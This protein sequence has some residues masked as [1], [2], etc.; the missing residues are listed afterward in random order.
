MSIFRKSRTVPST[1]QILAARK[2]VRAHLLEEQSEAARIQWL[3]STSPLG[4]V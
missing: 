3:K 1:K 4:R 2:D